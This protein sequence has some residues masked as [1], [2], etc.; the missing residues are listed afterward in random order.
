MDIHGHTQ[1]KLSVAVGKSRSYI[2]NTLRLLNLP[3]NVQSYVADGRLS[4]GHA[5]SLIGRDNAEELAE[6]IINEDLSVR[7]IEDL[8][9]DKVKP[10]KTQNSNVDKDINTSALEE[11]MSRIL[12]M[13]VSIQSGKKGNGS[14]KIKY[15][16]FDQLDHLVHKLTKI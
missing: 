9:K 1:E 10:S 7:A 8:T 13:Q 2:A 4:A 11:E 6:R 12:G 16:N 3:E 14:L 5:R 15:S